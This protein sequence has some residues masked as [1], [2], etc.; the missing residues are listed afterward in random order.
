[1]LTVCITDYVLTL[2]ICVFV[3]FT[4]QDSLQYYSTIVPWLTRISRPKNLEIMDALP[5][6]VLYSY[7]GF[8]LNEI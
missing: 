8:P 5:Y 4:K 2:Y 1:M 6:R 3:H 7:R